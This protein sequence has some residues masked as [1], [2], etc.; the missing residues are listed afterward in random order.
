MLNYHIFANINTLGMLR[1]MGRFSLI[2]LFFFLTPQILDAQSHKKSGF[3]QAFYSDTCTSENNHP[4]ELSIFVFPTLFPLDWSSPSSLYTSMITCYRKTLHI[5][6]HYLLGHLAIGLRSTLLP[7]PIV[8]GMKAADTR[9]RLDLVLKHKVGY[10]ILGAT[11]KGALESEEDLAE[12]METY[13]HWKK[14]SFLSYKINQ[15][16]AQRIIDFIQYFTKKNK[17][18]YAPCDYYSGSFWPLYEGEGASCASFAMALP[19][20]INI[21]LPEK[22]QWLIDL[23]VPMHLIGG[24]YNNNRKIRNR[25]LKSTKNW[26]SIE[27]QENIDYAPY[28]VYEP[29]RIFFW[30]HEKLAKPEEAYTSRTIRGVSGLVFD[31]RDVVVDSLSP[32]IQQRSKS[33][34]YIDI[35]RTKL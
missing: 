22:E 30:I 24:E 14:F 5:Q 4:H 1:L 25:T 3:L 11:L 8:T 20:L 15:K 34:L 19:E 35:F 31:K 2:L 29:N 27:G 10:A 6:N 17:L 28:C 23:K 21:H 18:D 13:I 32:M 16:A 26:H 9:E 12:K 7:K 33:D